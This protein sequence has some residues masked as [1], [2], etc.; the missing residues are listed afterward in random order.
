LLDDDGTFTATAETAG[1]WRF[2]AQV[3]GAEVSGNHWLDEIFAM[4][5]K[6]GSNIGEGTDSVHVVGGSYGKKIQTQAISIIVK[7][8]DGDKFEV[9]GNISHSPAAAAAGSPLELQQR[10][11][12]FTGNRVSG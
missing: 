2:S 6:N 10:G 7:V 1:I 12:N 4:I 9:Y 11:T 5:Y 3:S 8:E